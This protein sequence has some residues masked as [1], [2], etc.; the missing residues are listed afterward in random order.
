MVIFNLDNYIMKNKT[1][2][3]MQMCI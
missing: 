1:F 2:H 3:I